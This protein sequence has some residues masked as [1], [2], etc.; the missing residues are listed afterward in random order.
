MRRNRFSTLLVPDEKIDTVAGRPEERRPNRRDFFKVLGYSGLGALTMLV[1]QRLGFGSTGQV[2]SQ[3]TPN[4][5]TTAEYV[6]FP[7]Y[8]IFI[9][10]S[11]GNTIKARNGTTGK[12]DHSDTDATTVINNAINALGTTGGKLFLREGTY[13]IGDAILISSKTSL[14]G[15]GRGTVLQFDGGTGFD[16]MIQNKN[17]ST[18]QLETQTYWLKTW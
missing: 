6:D 1:G 17:I 18:G 5:T 13:S 3:D 14:V 11:D 15:S 2:Y 10:A 8:V 16:A 7:S 9:D 4:P 12:I